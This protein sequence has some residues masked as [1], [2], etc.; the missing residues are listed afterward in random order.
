M[1]GSACQV[2]PSPGVSSAQ[3]P[4][5]QG[6][7]RRFCPRAYSGNGPT[8]AVPLSAVTVY[9][10]L[11]GCPGNPANALWTVLMPS[12]YMKTEFCSSGSCT[13]E[14]PTDADQMAATSPRVTLPEEAAAVVSLKVLRTAPRAEVG[15]TS[16]RRSEERRVGK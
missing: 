4:S 13:S 6:R 15:I 5:P 11:C 2:L 1:G 14:M 7:A 9:V 16:A 8:A 12:V 10:S 3:A